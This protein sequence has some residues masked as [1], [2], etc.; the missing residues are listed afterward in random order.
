MISA[1]PGVGAG[2]HSAFYWED[3]RVGLE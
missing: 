2:P 1:K 3:G